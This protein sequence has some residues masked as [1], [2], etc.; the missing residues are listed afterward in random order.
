[1]G[2]R[3]A[4]ENRRRDFSNQRSS[5][6]LACRG[7]AAA[8][9]D[10]LVQD[11]QKACIGLLFGLLSALRHVNIIPSKAKHVCFCF[12]RKSTAH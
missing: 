4:C 5:V 1:M 11:V 12:R 3:G 10:V 9:L 2:T 8:R 6:W 7:F